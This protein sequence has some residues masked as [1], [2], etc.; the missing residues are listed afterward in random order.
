VTADS[1]GTDVESTLLKK[2]GNVSV[3]DFSVVESGEK[4]FTVAFRE[5]F[6]QVVDGALRLLHTFD[7][8]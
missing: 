5:A 7:N 1:D 8:V 4:C 3:T 2:C 6:H